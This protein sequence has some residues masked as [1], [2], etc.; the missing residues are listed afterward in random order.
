MAPKRWFSLGANDDEASSS[1][2]PLAALR[3]GGNRGGLHIGEAARGG[4]ALPQPAPLLL[5]PKPESSE[6]DP[7]FR[8]ALLISAAEEDEVYESVAPSLAG[9]RCLRGLVPFGSAGDERPVR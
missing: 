4:A 1:H 9:P 8:A 7:D 5:Q 3:A 2:R 6:E